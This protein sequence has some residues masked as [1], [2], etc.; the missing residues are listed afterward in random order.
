MEMILDFVLGF[1]FLGVLIYMSAMLITLKKCAKAA[2]GA[3]I[4]IVDSSKTLVDFVG[5]LDE[6]QIASYRNHQKSLDDLVAKVDSFAQGLPEM[7]MKEVP[8]KKNDWVSMKKAF[9]A[10]GTVGDLDE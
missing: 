9:R 10:P 5:A 1:A 7:A 2:N 8:I 4:A 6:R 3:L